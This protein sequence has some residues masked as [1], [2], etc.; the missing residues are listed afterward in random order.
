MI[1]A[2]QFKSGFVIKKDNSLYQVISAQHIKP[3]KG[4]AFVRVKLKNLKTG[5]TAEE[6]L[7]PEDSYPQA[8]IEEKKIQFLYKDH[9]I[10]HF[11]DQATYEQMVVGEQIMGD[12]AKFLK[13]GMEISASTHGG[14]IVG[15]SLPAFVDLKITYTE[16]GIKG[17]T[18]KGGSK[19]ATLE[20]G[21]VTRVPL[22]INTGDI[23]Q[24]DTRTGEYAG[25]A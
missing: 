3:G 7:R 16:P 10:Y 11:M 18:A 12:T 14:N 19:P 2:R 24:I 8:F 9:G 5:A 17:D 13:D 4:G 22:F 15:V 6:T 20:T 1:T 23:I 21:A 25:R